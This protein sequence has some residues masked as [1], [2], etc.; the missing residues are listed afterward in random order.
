MGRARKE[1]V[2][3]VKN[4]QCKGVVLGMEWVWRTNKTFSGVETQFVQGDVGQDKV[5]VEGEHDEV[6]AAAAQI[7]WACT[8]WDGQPPTILI[9]TDVDRG[10]AHTIAS[11]SD[12]LLKELAAKYPSVTT[13]F[14]GSEQTRLKLRGPEPA[15][16]HA[17]SE[18]LSHHNIT[19]SD[20]IIKRSR[21]IIKPLIDVDKLSTTQVTVKSIM[22]AYPNIKFFIPE[23]GERGVVCLAGIL[24][25]V[26]DAAKELRRENASTDSKRDNLSAWEDALKQ[27]EQKLKEWEERL[28]KRE[29][30]LN[31]ASLSK[32]GD[33][34]KLLE[35]KLDDD[36][37][38]SCDWTEYTDPATKRTFFYNVITKKSQWNKP[39]ELTVLELWKEKQKAKKEQQKIEQQKLEQEKLEQQKLEQERLKRE[40]Q[41]KLEQQKLEQQKLEQQRLEQQKIEQIK[42]EQM[43]LEQQKEKQKQMQEAEKQKQL[44]LQKQQVP[45]TLT[46]AQQL[47]L[48]QQLYQQQLL[49][50][51]VPPS[52]YISQHQHHHHHH[53]HQNQHQLQHQLQHQQQ[54]KH[55]KKHQHQHH[56]HQHQHHTHQ[57]QHQ[58]HQ[59]LHQHQHQHHQLHHHQAHH[60]EPSILEKLVQQ[61][62]QHQQQQQQHRQQNKGSDGVNVMELLMKQNPE[63]VS[64]EKEPCDPS[65][66]HFLQTSNLQYLEAAFRGVE[67]MDKLLALDF[68]E[69]VRRLPDP[70]QRGKVVD[71]VDSYRKKQADVRKAQLAIESLQSQLAQMNAKPT[72]VSPLPGLAIG[73]N[74]KKSETVTNDGV[75]K[76][77]GGAYGINVG[78]LMKGLGK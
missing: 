48:Q 71:A 63:V 35:M 74:A 13:H 27:K 25:E 51:S 64:T 72:G 54:N 32:D 69:L 61:Q 59:H 45:A 77:T 41:E 73:G 76:I 11:K 47:L 42:Q 52:M 12:K 10:H 66:R 57:H 7:R 39:E 67:S 31:S 24:E 55:Q 18:I 33:K 40:A 1:D 19:V 15:V 34:A 6:C 28:N 4:P 60:K 5:K 23:K 16:H 26:E 43:R 9:L 36:N 37:A 17:A 2:V 29:K 78:D 38:P 3:V 68:P 46:Q 75:T 30:L 14:K 21:T 58:H 49:M 65:I 50:H 8:P 22:A 20:Y 44:E 53:H 62:Q 70:K 56:Q